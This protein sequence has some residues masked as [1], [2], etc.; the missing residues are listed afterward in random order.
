MPQPLSKV[1]R[2]AAIDL[3]VSSIMEEPEL[4]AFIGYIIDACSILDAKMAESLAELMGT[5]AEF[6]VAIHYAIVSGP[7]HTEVL[8]AVAEKALSGRR[9]ELLQ[10][11]VELARK[12]MK[13]RHLM[14]HG[15]W[16]HSPDIPKA[17]LLIPPEVE[18]DLRAR[19]KSLFRNFKRVRK[20]PLCL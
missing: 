7:A 17:L 18:V 6:G 5:K 3:E 12:A 14:A 15:L 1:R 13:S 11:L 4:A 9:R 8:K 10:A 19:I 16:G 20:A 2:V